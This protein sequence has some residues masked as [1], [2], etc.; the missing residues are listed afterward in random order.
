M[1]VPMD[2]LGKHVWQM[3]NNH[4][5]LRPSLDPNQVHNLHTSNYRKYFQNRVL[6]RKCYRR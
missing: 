2:R 6:N 4:P 3:H 1:L 5:L